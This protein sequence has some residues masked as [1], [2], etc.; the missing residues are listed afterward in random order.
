MRL[1]DPN[2]GNQGS[3][4]WTGRKEM[5]KKTFVQCRDFLKT[6]GQTIKLMGLYKPEHP[7][8]TSA[9]Q[10]CFSYLKAIFKELEWKE[11]NFSTQDEKWLV[12]DVVLGQTKHIPEVL[13]D[14]FRHILPFN[15]EH[16]RYVL[17]D[18]RHGL[19]GTHCCDEGQIELV[20]RIFCESGFGQ[21]CQLGATDPR[22]GLAGRS[23][24]DNV[25]RLD[26]IEI[27]SR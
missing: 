1:D 24:D 5:T 20:S 4:H 13:S 11:I 19:P 25:G 3:G 21:A 8:P 18:E 27:E 12:D 16:A 26:L 6:L 14:L 15:G 22:V 17:H 2:Q 9:L 23:A 7:V 10:E